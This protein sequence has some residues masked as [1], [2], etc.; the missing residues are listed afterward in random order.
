[1]RNHASTRRTIWKFL[2]F[3]LYYILYYQFF[4]IIIYMLLFCDR[5]FLLIVMHFLEHYE[6]MTM[7]LKKM[8]LCNCRFALSDNLG[9]F[10]FSWGQDLVKVKIKFL[11]PLFPGYLMILMFFTSSWWC[12]HDHFKMPKHLLIIN[13]QSSITL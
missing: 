3:S 7:T 6:S 13:G 12:T 5:C 8:G 11:I 2:I 1:M 10:F 4:F 9:T